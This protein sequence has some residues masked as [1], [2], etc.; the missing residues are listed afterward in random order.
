[1]FFTALA[2]LLPYY[3]DELGISYTQAGV[4][5]G[6][7][8][9]GTF[10]AALP[11]GLL[12]SRWGYKRTVVSASALIG[13][14]AIGFGFTRQLWLLDLLRFGQGCASATALTAAIAWIVAVVPSER[15]GQMLG[16]TLGAAAT[17]SLLGPLLGGLAAAIGPGPAFTTAGLL[18]VPLLLVV[19]MLPRP[20]GQP[21][22]PLRRALT[23][24]S[25][26]Q[27]RISCWMI[28]LA[29]LVLGSLTVIVPLRLGELGW[30]A[31]A[32][33]A[34]FVIGGALESA[35]NPLVGRW[36][37]RRGPRRPALAALALLSIL[38]VLLG[39][40]GRPLLI[41]ALLAPAA[42]ALGALSVT[43]MTTL[44]AVAEQANLD[45]G[46]TISVMNLGW[47]PGNAIGAILGG[48]LIDDGQALIACLPSALLCLLTVA[49]L[50]RRPRD[51]VAARSSSRL[52]S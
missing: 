3:V 28:L 50:G 15:R 19:A 2:P 22:Q 34:S 1:M 23:F 11:A 16:T 10:V 41:A 48:M 31:T 40:A 44:S 26:P 29:A 30:T 37:D 32:I 49:V 20:A 24:T 52:D 43:A 38:M 9:A 21:A 33:S 5:S 4:M 47:A 36:A 14:F 45:R 25:Q 42:V 27:V 7:E 18:F 46:L 8:A 51:F 39:L 6:A 35:A 13:L 12:T 17:G